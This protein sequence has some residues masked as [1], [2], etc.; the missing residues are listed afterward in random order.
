M[1]RKL[2]ITIV[3]AAALTACAVSNDP[4][5]GGLFGG[6]HGLSSGAY[7]DRIR[8]RQDELDRQQTYNQE[9]KEQSETLESEVQLRDYQLTLEQQRV[10]RLERDLLNLESDINQLKAKSDKQKTEITTLQHKIKVQ[11]QKLKTQ[12]SALA[13]LDRAGGSAADPERY[14]VLMQERDNLTVEYKKLLE[15]SKNLSNATN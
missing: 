13:E 12:Q 5:Q 2:V 14:R 3:L 4:R 8:D 6:L 10:A 7:D 11:K 15:N 1:Y 9:L